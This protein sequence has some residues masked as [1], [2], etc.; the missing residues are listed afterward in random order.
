MSPELSQEE[1]SQTERMLVEA[2][3]EFCPILEK[4]EGSG[5][6]GSEDL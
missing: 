4:V 5:L 3:A 2:G 1:K 6:W